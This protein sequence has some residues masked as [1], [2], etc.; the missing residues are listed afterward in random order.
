MIATGFPGT[1]SRSQKR[2]SAEKSCIVV[3]SFKNDNFE[4]AMKLSPAP[5][6]CMEDF[7]AAAI[8]HDLSNTPMGNA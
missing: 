4:A 6:M 7:K 2:T 3:Y 8:S 1:V 5:E